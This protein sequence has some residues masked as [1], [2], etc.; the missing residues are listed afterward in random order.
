MREDD[1]TFAQPPGW[2]L[3]HIWGHMHLK[4]AY[5]R[6]ARQKYSDVRTA[7]AS[8]K[9]TGQGEEK[10]EGRGGGKQNNAGAQRSKGAR[11]LRVGAGQAYR[12]LPKC[13]R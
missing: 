1:L 5:L 4:V 7:F 12:N 6:V 13:T 11:G 2:H 10:G 9:G 3:C 8:P